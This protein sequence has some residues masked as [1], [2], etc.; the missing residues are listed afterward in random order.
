[1]ARQRW[2]QPGRP[3][4]TRSSSSPSRRRWTPRTR[5]ASSTSVEDELFRFGR[6]VAGDRELAPHP[7]R[8]HG[9]G[10]GQGGAARRLLAGKVSPVTEQL[11]RN[12][13]DRLRTPAH[14]RRRDRAARPSWPA[15]GA[16]SRSRDVT[17]A[18][19]ADRGEEQRLADVLGRLYGRKI[20]LQ[21][22]VDPS[23]ARR[24]GVQV[25]DE[26]IDGS[27]AHRLDAAGRRL[28]G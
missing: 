10:R 12:V 9:A 22:D 11:L 21:V 3:A 15:A 26:V 4:S 24:A 8:P 17:T 6:I 18:V 2:S 5:A 13:L 20:G 23:V 27:I 1:M 25:G 28:A 14:V 19:A 7:Q 16:A